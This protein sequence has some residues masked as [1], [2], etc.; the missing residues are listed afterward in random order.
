MLGLSEA[1]YQPNKRSERSL[2]NSMDL[3]PG[4]NKVMNV[5]GFWIE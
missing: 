2:V 3:S 1:V 5:V 4:S